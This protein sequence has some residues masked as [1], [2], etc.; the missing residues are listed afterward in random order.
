MSLLL[1]TV[2]GCATGPEGLR[3]TPDGSG[4][5]VRVDWDAEP[6]PEIP[7]PNDLATRNDPGSPTGLRL[8]ISEDAPTKLEREARANFNKLTGFGIFAPISVAFQAPLDLD[9][10]YDRQWDDSDFSD[11]A[12]YVINVDP[13]SPDYGQ[14]AYLDVGHGRY[15]MDL[16][17]EDRYFPNDPH[18][19]GTALYFET[20]EEDLNGNGRMDPGEDTDHDGVLDHPN[21]YPEGGSPRHDLMTWYERETDTLILRL[22]KPLREQTTYAVVLTERLVGEDGEP[23]R[24]PWEWVNHT[25]QT[26]ALRPLEDILPTLGVAQDELAYAWTFT[27]GRVTGDL[28]DIRRGFDGEG[29]WPFLQTDYPGK[30]NEALVMHEKD[31]LDPFMLPMRELVDALTDI[32]FFDSVAGDVLGENYETFAA[33]VV[34]GSFTSAALL[35]DRDDGG[36][37]THDEYWVT[38]P[39]AGTLEVGTERI[40]F[41][42]VLPKEREGVSPPYDVAIFGHGYGSSRFDTLGFA[43][44]FNRLG[45][46]GCGMDFPG[47]GA[48]IDEEEEVLLEAYLRPQGF[49]PFADHIFDDRARDLTNDGLTNSGFD[50]WISDGFHTR[51]MVRQAVVD[52]M[53]MIRSLQAC[54]TGEMTRGDGSATTCD[55]DADGRVDIGGPNAKF[56]VVGGSL[57]GIDSAV[58]AAVEP[59]VSAFSPI[60]GGG[61]LMDIGARSPLSGAVEAVPGRLMTPLFLGYPTETGGIEVFQY[62]SQFMDMQERRIGVIDEVPAGGKVTVHNL[63]N[64]ET[65]QTRIPDDG[66]FRVGL[67]CDAADAYEKRVIAGIPHTGPDFGATYTVAD[68]AQLGDRLRIHIQRADGKTVADWDTWQE[69]TTYE[70]V[71]MP[72]GSDLVALSE[73]LGHQRGSPDLR[74]LVQTISLATEPGDPISYAPHYVDDPFEALWGNAGPNVL[75]VSTPG[76]NIVSINAQ[77]SLARAAGLIETTEVD[78]RY[79]TTVDRWLIDN[80]VVRGLEQWGPFT[81]GDD[82]SPCLFDPDDLDDGLDGLDAPSDA[83]LRVHRD[84][85]WGGITALRMPYV[86]TSGSHGPGLPDPTLPFD[87]NTWFIYQVGHFFL[88]DGTALTDDHCME[89]ASC[90]WIPALEGS[91]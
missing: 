81:C 33:G 80:E 72:A 26:D 34:G 6:L 55:W 84:A 69:E 44:A 15:P 29:P 5:L 4:P 76:D 88:N 70:G 16:D 65:R 7:F 36:H 41:T 46:A 24:S 25:R 40:P 56:Y 13:D 11:D 19:A 52:W 32:G 91:R 20:V 8:N 28:V 47:H 62:V 58:L 42:C 64:G 50:Q 60:V 59:S 30:V 82:E 49:M 27:T 75:L 71:T 61:G 18:G 87:I 35:Y 37:D 14:P 78:E 45:M 3:E 74:R 83:P 23:V 63:S 22:V 68:T 53:M 73:G 89:D 17:E 31:G 12:V 39:V 21:V 38:D 51:D 86:R 54:G 10:V 43:Y 67:P 48:S 90:D 2:L 77:I 79:G 9:N 57:G 85:P 1:A 66:R